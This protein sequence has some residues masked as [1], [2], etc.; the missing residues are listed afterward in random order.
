[1]T[2]AMCSTLSVMFV[3]LSGCIGL[4][5]E[6]DEDP[7][8]SEGT[9]ST[10]SSGSSS[11]DASGAASS[12][13]TAGASSGSS[14]SSTSSTGSADGQSST[15]AEPPLCEDP[16][17][18]ACAVEGEWSCVDP[19]KNDE[20]CGRC[21]HDC[22]VYGDA[23]CKEGECVC[24]GNRQLCGEVCVDEQDPAA[25]GEDCVD[26]RELYGESAECHHGEC[27]DDN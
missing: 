5:P 23:S 21:S 7:R 24:D 10:S 13:S 27:R 6:W 25:C 11:S 8:A 16:D 12:G 26:C 3:A 18:I 20:H 15:T 4:N 19:N 17:R 2:K 9:E 14:T 22:S 1:M